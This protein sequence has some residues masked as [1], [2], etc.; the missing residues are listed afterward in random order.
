MNNRPATIT[1]PNRFAFLNVRGLLTHERQ[2]AL[3][4]VLRRKNIPVC[5]VAE[6]WI[7]GHYE[8]DRLYEKSKAS[9]TNFSFR[10]VTIGKMTHETRQKNGVGIMLRSDVI[11]CKQTL[12]SDRLATFL[13]DIAGQ[14]FR[15]VICYAPTDTNPEDPDKQKE[16]ATFWRQLNV[17]T[18]KYAKGK[19]P[20]VVLGDFNCNLGT[21]HLAPRSVLMPTWAG[22]SARPT[23]SNGA[24]LVTFAEKFK[25][26]IANSFFRQPP[27]GA[28]KDFILVSAHTFKVFRRVAVDNYWQFGSDHLPLVVTYKTNQ[29]QR[30]LRPPKAAKPLPVTFDFGAT[31]ADFSKNTTTMVTYGTAQRL[32]RHGT[33]SRASSASPGVS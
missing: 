24:N 18:A 21:D 6:S 14:K 3:A 19:I 12:V 15:F 27:G 20:C 8:T 32:N 17:T 31:K 28:V 2:F 25:L 7:P 1:I 13:I 4:A 26:K 5:A 29:R 9:S 10:L 30:T 11:L 16:V 23:S 33:R 22:L